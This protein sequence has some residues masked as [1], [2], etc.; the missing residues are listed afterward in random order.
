M[1]TIQPPTD[2]QS[3]MTPAFRDQS[4]GLVVFGVLQIV[5]G[6]LS[7]LLALATLSM[8]L[9]MGPMMAKA[10]QNLA[11]TRQ[12]LAKTQ[13]DFPK[14]QPE[15]TANAAGVGAK[16][17]LGETAAVGEPTTEMPPFEPANMRMVIPGALMYL[18]PAVVFIWL[19][20]GSIRAR[21]WAWTLTV[22]L[23]WL[24]L[25]M[26]VAAMIG[27]A[28]TVGPMISAM[29]EQ[30]AKM[31]GHGPMPHAMMVTMLVVM[32]TFTVCIYLVL[33][34]VFVLFYHRESVRAT[35]QRRDPRIPW[36]DRCPM[37]VL[38]LS[39]LLACGAALM[40][41]SA[42]IY[43]AIPLFGVLVSGVAA[44]VAWLLMV[45]VLGYLAW[46]AYRLKMAAWWAMLLLCIAGAVS[47]WLNMVYINPLEM[48]EKMGLPA[49]QVEMMQKMGVAQW[50]SPGQIAILL[51]G[52][53]VWL[54]Y[55]LYVRRHFVR[56]QEAE[57]NQALGA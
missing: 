4:M 2:Q 10:H 9:M 8:A 40:L 29:T 51:V 18:L 5:L 41:P 26:G 38:A 27:V 46:A 32:G 13:Q 55:L 52:W 36:T 25:I 30:Q 39:I 23:S 17:P 54:G 16:T 37:P 11:K 19:G 33:P 53:V 21:R 28:F 57:V 45:L 20:I 7:A 48:Y 56:S 50:K 1:S 6:C 24:W 49:A 44:V 31:P 14:A 34:L 12:K 15:K 47:T 42:V 35:C 22:V 3:T 43:G